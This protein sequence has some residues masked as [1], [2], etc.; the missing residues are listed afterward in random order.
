MVNAKFIVCFALLLF[1]KLASAQ[2]ITLTLAKAYEQAVQHY[3]LIK[4]RQ[5]LQQT[6][7][8]TVDNLS[9]GFLPQV[10]ISAQASYQ[11][12]VTKVSIPV[13]GITITPPSK[14]QYKVLADVSQ[15]VYDGGMIK[16]QKNVQHLNEDAE[17]EKIEVELYKLKDRI[18]QLYLGVL[19]LDEQLKQIELVQND[20]QN[21]IAK[22]EAQVNNGVAFRSNLNVLKAESLKNDQRAIE[23]KATRKGFIDVISLFIGENLPE[24]VQLEMPVSVAPSLQADIQRP[25]LKLYST[26]EKLLSGQNA[27]IDA[28]NKPRASLFVQGGYGRPGLNFLNNDFAF[29]YTTGVRLNWSLSGLYTQ[30]KE[31]QIID[32]SRKTIGIQKETFLL[33]TNT[34]LKQQDA[35]INKLQQLIAKDQAIIDL[36]ASVKDAAKAQLDNAVITANDYLREVN[37]EDQARQSLIT[38]KVQLLQAEI[39]YQTISGNQ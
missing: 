5:L 10:N 25:E 37:A 35:E 15:L 17:Q 18:N 19:Y 21:G 2:Q 9:K 38:H 4:Q 34:A 23:L 6:T 11:S 24:N 32:I 8:L 31:K 28:R 13:P 1:T 3:P 39:N 26:Q 16:E 29:F 12:D 20:I 7:N 22:T 33:N 30:K 14:D 27:I 36:R